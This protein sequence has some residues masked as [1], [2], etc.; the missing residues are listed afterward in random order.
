MIY[1]NRRARFRTPGGYFSFGNEGTKSYLRGFG[2]G[3]SI[4]LRDEWGNVWK[5][6]A[7]KYGDDAVHYLFR[8]AN[9]RTL[10]GVSDRYGVILRDEKG[11]TWRGFVD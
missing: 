8:D 3:D 10:R 9:G 2:H 11:R 4:R 1:R 6:S 7:E 5:G